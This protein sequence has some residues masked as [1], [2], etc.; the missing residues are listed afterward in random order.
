MIMDGLIFTA[1]VIGL[2]YLRLNGGPTIILQSTVFWIILFFLLSSLYI[3]GTYDLDRDET[4]SP[5]VLRN[6][7]AVLATF[8]AVILLNY[9]VGSDRAGLFGR[10]ILLGSLIVYIAV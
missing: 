7:V 9:L 6:S 10:G 1:I 8:L 2:F 3:F 5:V 4:Y